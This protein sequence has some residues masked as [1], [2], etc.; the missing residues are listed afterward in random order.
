MNEIGPD[1]QM[2]GSLI[3]FSCCEM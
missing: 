1:F 3:L 2:F